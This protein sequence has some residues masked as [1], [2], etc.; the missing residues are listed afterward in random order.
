METYFSY[1]PYEL[2]SL[3]F[4]YLRR[5]VDIINMGDVVKHLVYPTFFEDLF[6][7][8][9]P[10]L[11]NGE[12]SD[13]FF[14]KDVIN[15][16]I[17]LRKTGMPWLILYAS[18]RIND[19]IKKMK[20]KSYYSKILGA[21]NTIV[22]VLFKNHFEEIYNKLKK[23]ES[24]DFSHFNGYFSNERFPQSYDRHGF[25]WISLLEIYFYINK[26]PG[27]YEVL[28]R[29]DEILTNFI[30]SISHQERIEEILDVI[31]EDK[32][33]YDFFQDNMS[34]T[35]RFNFILLGQEYKDILTYIKNKGI[36]I[37]LNKLNIY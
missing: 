12:K 1:I 23:L 26:I 37:S 31:L 30:I 5:D 29:D 9:Y 15:D 24:F 2:L 34:I 20:I 36:K 19:Y 6:K 32:L 16:D 28:Y 7:M 27:R 10:L 21:N 33:I 17:Y 18:L 25:D 14:L 35:L 13:K 8:S 22:R 11:Y 3:V 4:E